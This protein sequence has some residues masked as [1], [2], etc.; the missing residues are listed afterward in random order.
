MSNLQKFV[1]R[2]IGNKRATRVATV[3]SEMRITDFDGQSSGVWVVDLEVGS[4]RPMVNVPV[5][6]DKNRF[7]A[8]LGQSVEIRRN[9]HGR[10]EVV[11]PGDHIAAT[12][13]VRTYDLETQTQQ[14]TANA[15]FSF[16][17]V[18]FSYY[19]TLD[20]GAPLGVLWADG[21]TPFGL[22]QIIDDATGLP[23]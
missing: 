16:N 1:R 23:V 4:S 10:W 11:G 3:I 9:A 18:P 8:Q 12:M 5:K 6:A 15:G 14:S 22:V 7:Y 13:V 17:R 2:E 19:A 20:G 21:A